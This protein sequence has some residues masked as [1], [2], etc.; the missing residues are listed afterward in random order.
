MVQRTA[1]SGINRYGRSAQGVKTMNVREGD[2]VSAVAMVVED[3]EGNVE[4]VEGD[5]LEATEAPEATTVEEIGEEAAI[6][7]E[8][9]GQEA[10]D[11]A[12][13]ADEDDE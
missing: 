13:A 9:A 2:I 7:E 12:E 1:V 3:A 6:V 5:E 11:E 4:E 10:G 8:E